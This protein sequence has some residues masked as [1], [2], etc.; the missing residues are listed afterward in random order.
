MSLGIT[1]NGNRGLVKLILEIL[2]LHFGRAGEL[3]FTRI[4]RRRKSNGEK[5]EEEEV[6]LEPGANFA[7]YHFTAAPRMRKKSG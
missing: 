4:N 6:T 3:C 1:I 5:A 2:L 7:L